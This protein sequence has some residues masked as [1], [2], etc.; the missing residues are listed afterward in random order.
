MKERLG[1]FYRDHIVSIFWVLCWV[2]SAH[3]APRPNILFIAVDDLRPALGCY[4][5]P[6]MQTHNGTL[7]IDALANQGTTFMNHHVALPICGASRASLT[8]GLMPEEH[9]V[10]VFPALRHPTAGLPNAVTL[11][12]YFK[13]NGY[14]TAARGKFHDGRTVGDTT[15]PLQKI[16]KDERF[17]HG[18]EVDDPIS[19][20]FSFEGAFSGAIEHGSA[21]VAAGF[22]TVPLQ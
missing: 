13:N 9:G 19:W 16:G 2:V 17:P 5:D 1:L 10:L 21:V 8:T 3:A 20:T 7:R 18:N 15:Q 6:I 14:T 4:D 22:A 11:P 12:Q